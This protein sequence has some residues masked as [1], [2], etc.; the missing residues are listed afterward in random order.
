MLKAGNFLVNSPY[1]PRK[2]CGTTVMVPNI[3]LC[4]SC[5]TCSR[6]KYNIFN[7]RGVK[8]SVFD[9]A[10]NM[11]SVTF[12]SDERNHGAYI[13]RPCKR[14]FDKYISYQQKLQ[15]LHDAV[16]TNSQKFIRIQRVKRAKPST[17]TPVKLTS[18][19]PF[20]C[21]SLFFLQLPA[22]NNP[23]RLRCNQIGLISRS[24]LLWFKAP[25]L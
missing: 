11:Y 25:I 16:N 19:I 6:D 7:E 21:F 15:A 5:S 13:C 10:N 18:G 4:V 8:G 24:S 3:S 14:N 20:T 23:L 1:T 12:S 17:S 2:M 22:I 9:M